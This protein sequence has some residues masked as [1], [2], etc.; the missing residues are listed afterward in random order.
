MTIPRWRLA[1]AAGAIIVL[2]ALGGG[3]VQA[4]AAQASTPPATSTASGAPPTGVTTGPTANGSDLPTLAAERR[5]ALRERLGDGGL[6]RL[7]KH[8]VHGTITVLD[9]DGK[10]ITLQLDHGTV[11]AIGSGSVSI[12]EAGG[13]SVTVGT[14]AET[15]VRKDRKP[16]SLT[17]LA[18][19]DEVVVVSI[20]TDG[21][22]TARRIVVPP[23]AP[24]ATP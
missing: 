10:L 3:V 17:D 2:S 9:R 5:L 18:V 8:L 23:T 21:T 1:L 14:T 22:A 20:V 13:T 16:A 4:V 15:R 12:A 11:S 19:G 6:G 7:R 24:T